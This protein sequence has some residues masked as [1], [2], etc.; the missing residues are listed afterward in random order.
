MKCKDIDALLDAH[1][2]AQ[3]NTAAKAEIASHVEQCS[4][5]ADAWLSHEA[6]AGETPAAPRE[7]FYAEALAA[8]VAD[9][10]PNAEKIAPMMAIAGG[11]RRHRA[12]LGLAAAAVVAVGLVWLALPD[13]EASDE[14]SLFGA[15][16]ATAADDSAESFSPG[17]LGDTPIREI[18]AGVPAQFREAQTL[19]ALLN[20]VREQRALEASL[21]RP[22]TF[23]AGTHYERLPVAAPTTA[24]GGRVEVCEFF[25]FSCLHCY[26]LEPL[27]AS[28]AELRSDSVELVRVPALWNDITVLHAQAYYTAEA[29]G[30]VDT[31]LGPFYA[32]IH[33]RGRPLASVADIRAFFVRL[34]IDG[35]RFD[36]T[37]DSAE[38]RGDLRRAAE[39][40]RLYGVDS[41]PT[42]GVAGKY[43]TG[44][45]MAGSNE[46]LFD[47]ID[48]LVEA[49]SLTEA[50]PEAESCV[51]RDNCPA[52]LELRPAVDRG[53]PSGDRF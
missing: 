52:R 29:L 16:P 48:S 15:D 4:R 10:D 37:F 33:D 50:L 17:I 7:G 8:A 44:V 26:A 24:D 3:L 30:A 38:V 20:A 22:S 14:G 31:I 12:A 2:V 39:L 35:E 43:R 40:N 28:W 45:S 53:F 36:A 18:E 23:V 34:G 46:A 13:E 47:V 27:L 49:E 19:E 9:G 21:A 32:E 6:L 51:G 1:R 5:C 25:L 11:S 41:T 42:I